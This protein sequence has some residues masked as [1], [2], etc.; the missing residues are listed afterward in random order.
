MATANETPG[1]VDVASTEHGALVDHPQP[2]GILPTRWFWKDKANRSLVRWP[3]ALLLWVTLM[4]IA[5]LE[6]PLWAWI[7][8]S[9]IAAELWLGLIERYIRYKAK[10][11]CRSHAMPMAE[12]RPRG[13]LI[14]HSRSVAV[15]WSS[16][17]YCRGVDSSS[18]F[19]SGHQ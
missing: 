1:A 7:L 18:P 14:P 16:L 9:V 5:V 12:S 8:A 6:P 15:Y 10:Q 19:V 11:R 2:L 13:T 3:Y 17:G 4:V